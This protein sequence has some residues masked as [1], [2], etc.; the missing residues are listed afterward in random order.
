MDNHPK[1]EKSYYYV[2]TIILVLSIVAGYLLAVRNPEFAGDV[3]ESALA[4]F[5]AISEIPPIAVFFVILFN[6]AL[7]A[8][9]AILLGFF[10]GLFPLYFIITNGN[11]IGLVIALIAAETGILTVMAGLLPHGIIELTAIVIAASHGL[12]LGIRFIRK[13]LYKESFTDAFRASMRAY[14]KII[15]PLIFAAAVIETYITPA[16]L[17]LVSR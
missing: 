6:N 14:V 11:I 4:P 17:Q 13:I 2:I 7:K 12:W 15:L 5:Q 16:I 1:P 8:L 3:V 10:L 9:F